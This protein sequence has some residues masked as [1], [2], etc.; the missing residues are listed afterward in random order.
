MIERP[1]NLLTCSRSYLQTTM[2]ERIAAQG[3]DFVDDQELNNLYKAS[4][5]R[6]LEEDGRIQ[7]AGNI[8]MGE[9]I[10]IVDSD[11]RVVSNQGFRVYQQHADKHSQ[12][13][14]CFMEP[15]RCFCRP[16]WL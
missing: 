9:I 4:L 13:T 3:T 7:A 14:V 8:R 2:D 15:P 10:L 16:R 5:A 6:V 12:S 11:T 1:D